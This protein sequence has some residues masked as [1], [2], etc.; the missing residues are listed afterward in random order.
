MERWV[1]DPIEEGTGRPLVLPRSSRDGGIHVQ[2]QQIAPASPRRQWA[3]RRE[4][5]LQTSTGVDNIEITLTL[6][7]HS[8]RDQWA[9]ETR[10]MGALPVEAEGDGDLPGWNGSVRVVTNDGSHVLAMA[11]DIADAIAKL[12]REHGTLAWTS[13][14]GVR[15]YFD[16]VAAEFV[17][18][19]PWD[20]RQI[21]ARLAQVQIKLT[22][23]PWLREPEQLLGTV[24]T[25]PGQRLAVL[26]D[27]YVPGDVDALARLEF[28][29]A[30]DSQASLLYAIDQPDTPTK[31]LNVQLAAASRGTP[32]VVEPH[33]GSVAPTVVRVS[34]SLPGV[35]AGTW[36]TLLHLRSTTGQPIVI[37]GQH[38]VL[39][40]VSCSTAAQLQLRLRWS[41]GARE[42]GM[43]PEPIW[44]S[45]PQDWWE[46]ADL[47]IIDVPAGGTLDGVIERLGPY[48]V[49]THLDLLLFVPVGRAQGSAHASTALPSGQVILA[50]DP[51]DGTGALGG[52]PAPSGG[53]WAGFGPGTAF[54]RSSGVA[55]RTAAAANRRA[56][57]LPVGSA[58]VTISA[59]L[60]VAPTPLDATAV[61]GLVI[62]NALGIDRVLQG[63]GGPTGWAIACERND[64]H[65]DGSTMVIRT[66][67]G[68]TMRAVGVSPLGSG[69]IGSGRSSLGWFAEGYAN[70]ILGGTAAAGFVNPPPPAT[71]IYAGVYSYG[72]GDGF[73]GYGSP[74]TVTVDDVTIVGP[75]P[76]D[77]V[78]WPART[79][80]ITSSDATRQTQE[81]YSG[82]VGSPSGARPVL[83]PSGRA[84]R[85]VRV[86]AGVFRDDL[87]V[88]LDRYP[89]D[90]FTVAVYARP[91]WTLHPRPDGTPG[92]PSGL[93][94]A[95]NVFPGPDLLPGG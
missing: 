48:P 60:G 42:G 5:A 83:P 61:Y 77:R 20:D 17:E 28:S 46:I 21:I 43:R 58:A 72:A 73:G 32:G 23:L 15:G 12:E 82:S 78:L 6:Q 66:V 51:M 53:T 63:P 84:N 50:A 56:E 13:D 8:P 16:I 67:D 37:S 2:A 35:P 9:E 88:G 79:A 68:T 94:P 3:E 86:V 57:A 31:A 62:G 7:L 14:A 52:S 80:T 69:G 90:P 93:Y 95:P 71:G 85:L 81:G 30:S 11:I 18:S 1:I 87:R 39:V 38:R 74:V 75:T 25:T 22:C 26:S 64:A 29:G 89:A 40:R 92:P 70:A 10:D 55:T 44:T 24:T 33:A 19:L 41:A 65:T 4:G 76:Q 45:S 59:Q 54:V 27:I 49:H 47:G 34:E 91:R 36:E